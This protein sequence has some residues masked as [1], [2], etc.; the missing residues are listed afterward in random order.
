MTL[1]EW[2]DTGSACPTVAARGGGRGYSS[3]TGDRGT[4]DPD[5]CPGGIL[6]GA[7]VGVGGAARASSRVAVG[8]RTAGGPQQARWCGQV[9]TRT[10]AAFADTIPDPYHFA[11]RLSDVLAAIDRACA[12]SPRIR[13]VVDEL[14]RLLVPRNMQLMLQAAAVPACG[15]HPWVYLLENL[16]APTDAGLRRRAAATSRRNRL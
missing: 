1:R 2:Q 3:G 7:V 16:W 15:H 11:G 9:G 12:S 8:L 4:G 6:S 5:S 14:N 10:V 13:E